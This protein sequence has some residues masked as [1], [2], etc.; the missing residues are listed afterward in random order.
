MCFVWIS[1]QTAIISLYNI[2]WLA[3]VT[4]TETVYCAVRTG[5]LNKLDINSV[6]PLFNTSSVWNVRSDL[7]PFML[8]QSSLSPFPS[9]VLRHR[10][11]RDNCALISWFNCYILQPSFTL[12]LLPSGLHPSQPSHPPT[13]FLI[14]SRKKKHTKK[15][16]SRKRNLRTQNASFEI[17]IPLHL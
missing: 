10:N 9:L 3:F 7:R 5:C 4:E 15:E 1:E 13:S 6:F 12:P 2:N 11:L 14:L 17:E 16:I 8:P